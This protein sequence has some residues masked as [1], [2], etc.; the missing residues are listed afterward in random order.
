MYFLEKLKQ[1]LAKEVNKKLGC[2]LVQSQDFEYPPENAKGGDLA[3]P[4]FKLA[5]ALKKSPTKLTTEIKNKWIE[6]METNGP[7]INFYLKR[8][9]VAKEILKNVQSPTLNIGKGEKVMLEYVSPNSNKPLHLGHIRNAFLGE[10]LANIME[11]AGHKVKRSCLVNDRGVAICKAMLAYKLWGK[12]DTPLKSG[13]KP[14]HF[15]GK[16][17][18]MFEK[19]KTRLALTSDSESRRGPA[20][21]KQAQ[22]MLQ[23]WEKGDRATVALWK[24][25]QKW[26]LDGYE[27]TYKRLGVSF[28][29][30][31]YESE[32]YKDGKKIVEEYLKKK[33]FSKD[34][35]GNIVAKLEKCNLP[36][37]IML[38]ADGTA[39]YSTNDLALA[40]E[41]IREGYKKIYYVV[42]SEQDLYF[43]QLFCVLGQLDFGK[44]AELKHLSY[45]LVELP[46]GRMKSREGTVVDADDLL[47]KME[48]LA[49][50]EVKARNDF[51]KQAE[52]DRRAA[53]IA[54]AALK[55]YILNV[56]PATRIKFNPKESINFTGKT[57]PYLLYSYARLH[58]ILRK[59]KGKKVVGLREPY[60]EGLEKDE[61]WEM[62]LE[63]A[64]FPEAVL[65]A[66]EGMD[67]EEVSSYLYSLSGNISDFYHKVRV[68]EAEPAERQLLMVVIENVLKT[69]ETGLGLLGIEVLE[70]M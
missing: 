5:K 54:S 66:V 61:V 57:G 1:E 36:D 55:F 6:R 20:L 30:V 12:N 34:E 58:S 51:I 45:G 32:L 70:E 18:V 52:S 48:E 69:M 21:E 28:D 59:S 31:Y 10:A 37:K 64:K 67:P 4:L 22:E 27:K 25:M 16:Y 14:D 40:K 56:N 43:K 26:V 60:S 62:I 17:Y 46:E 9:A 15:V 39:I 13:M 35:K 42:G 33:K 41:R 68:L 11:F 49:G 65:S 3:L 23:K 8:G 53:I 29:K 63:V 19:K 47:D 24:T 7:Y 38:R 44:T 2:K 50:K